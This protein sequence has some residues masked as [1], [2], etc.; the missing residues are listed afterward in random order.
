MIRVVRTL[1]FSFKIGTSVIQINQAF[2]KNFVFTYSYRKT[3][4]SRSIFNV[5]LKV[6][7]KNW[8]KLF[9]FQNMS[10]IIQWEL[11]Y[12][13]LFKFSI[14]KKKGGVERGRINVRRI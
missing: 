10:V 14:I 6:K 5:T 8:F 2:I 11:I 13:T 12:E 3:D 1:S 7:N 9:I 4:D